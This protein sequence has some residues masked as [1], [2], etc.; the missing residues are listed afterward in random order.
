MQWDSRSWTGLF[1]LLKQTI[2][3]RSNKLCR[4][5]IHCKWKMRSPRN[6][7]L[8]SMLSNFIDFNRWCYHR[9][10]INYWLDRKRFKLAFINC[11]CRCWI[12]RLW[13]NGI[14][15]WWWC[16]FIFISVQE[17]FRKRYCAICSLLIKQRRFNET[18]KRDFEGNSL[19][20]CRIFS[21]EKYSAKACKRIW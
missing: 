10:L 16:S 19:I 12:S 13:V 5:N 9:S 11:D 17:I 1:K 15:W 21:K 7:K 2:V 4:C 20:A 6:F 3:F 8:E 18:C 14:A